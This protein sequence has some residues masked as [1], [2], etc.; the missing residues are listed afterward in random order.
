MERQLREK[1]KTNTWYVILKYFLLKSDSKI[2]TLKQLQPI[3]LN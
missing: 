1:Q 3:I 2:Q